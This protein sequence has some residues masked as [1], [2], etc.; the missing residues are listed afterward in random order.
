MLLL[1][2]VI[3]DQ[4]YIFQEKDN[5][6]D[7]DFK[8]PNSDRAQWKTGDQML[9]I[10]QS[11]VKVIVSGAVMFQKVSV[12]AINTKRCRGVLSQI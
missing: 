6:Y 1:F 2:V 5:L 8:N 7:L 4:S 12:Q 3:G 11:F 10:Y 9:D